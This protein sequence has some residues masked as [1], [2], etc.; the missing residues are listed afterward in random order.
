MLSGDL[1]LPTN[2]EISRI[3]VPMGDANTVAFFD[4]KKRV[5]YRYKVTSAAKTMASFK[6]SSETVPVAYRLNGKHLLT[7]T[8]S[9]VSLR[10]YSYLVRQMGQ[11][12]FIFIFVCWHDHTECNA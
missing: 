1:D 8:L 6:M 7:D 11:K 9:D 2:A 10:S 4:D 5:V 3:R 12:L